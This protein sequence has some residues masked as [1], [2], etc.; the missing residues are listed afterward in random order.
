[1]IYGLRKRVD[2]YY[3]LVVRNLRDVIPKQ[4]INFLI[5]KSQKDLSLAA[6]KFI[7]D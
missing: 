7:N 1:M 6:F 2:A 3:K 5:T 4:I